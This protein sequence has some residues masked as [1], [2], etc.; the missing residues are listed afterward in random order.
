MS[1]TYDGQA[2]DSPPITVCES[3]H[4]LYT[5]AGYEALGDARRE[6][7][8]YITASAYCESRACPCG[9]RPGI[10]RGGES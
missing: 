9:G 7:P 2:L 4:T 1:D 6:R 5:R 10:V 3:C 8:Q